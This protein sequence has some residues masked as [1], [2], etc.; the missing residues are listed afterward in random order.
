[1]K[2]MSLL[3]FLLLSAFPLPAQQNS[4]DLF[5]DKEYASLESLYEYL[6][7]NPELSYNEANTSQRIAEELRKLGFEGNGEGRKVLRTPPEPATVLLPF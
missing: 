3:P 5:V 1:M 4:V 6:H 7:S 2:A